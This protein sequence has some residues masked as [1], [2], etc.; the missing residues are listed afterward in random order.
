MQI[1]S[2]RPEPRPDLL[3]GRGSCAD[4]HARIFAGSCGELAG[5]APNRAT[6]PAGVTRA[7]KSRH[8]RRH[9]LPIAR[10]FRD[11]GRPSLIALILEVEA[12]A[13]LKATIVGAEVIVSTGAFEL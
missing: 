12:G 9:R 2:Y 6:A 3:Q 8:D 11:W 1:S 10:G 7:F 13:F 4:E 5:P